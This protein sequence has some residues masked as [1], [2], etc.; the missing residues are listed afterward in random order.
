MPA[1]S[2]FMGVISSLRQQGCRRSVTRMQYP[3]FAKQEDDVIEQ[4]FD[5]RRTGRRKGRG[6]R[7]K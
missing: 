2:R 6:Q 5:D 7:T 4:N 3:S 1:V